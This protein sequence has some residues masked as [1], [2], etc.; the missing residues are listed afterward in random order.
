MLI[1]PL[2]EGLVM[3]LTAPR[4]VSVALGRGGPRV[5]ACA[6]TKPDFPPLP[7]RLTR[8][9]ARR[10]ISAGRITSDVE[11][12]GPLL[13]LVTHGITD[14][15]TALDRRLEREGVF[16][17]GI[18][19]EGGRSSLLQGMLFP[20]RLASPTGAG[21]ALRAVAE[22]LNPF[23]SPGSSTETERARLR[24]APAASGL[25]LQLGDANLT[26]GHITLALDGALLSALGQGTRYITSLT[27]EPGYPP[28]DIET[29]P[30]VWRSLGAFMEWLHAGELYGWVLPTA[31]LCRN[32]VTGIGTVSVLDRP[33]SR[34]ARPEVRLRELLQP[35]PD[36][37]PSPISI[38]VT[39][40]RHGWA[41]MTISAGGATADVTLS[42]VFF[43]LHDL[44]EWAARL[45]AGDLPMEVEVDEEGT[46]A[47]L[48]AHP[49]AEP[50][51]V[52]LTIHERYGTE[53]RL[54]AL[55]H[56]MALAEALRDAMVRSL[57]D[58]GQAQGWEEFVREPGEE[59]GSLSAFRT[60]LGQE[61]PWLREG[62]GDGP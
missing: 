13:L 54:Q 40:D 16:Q 32:G 30:F 27:D 31:C 15:R 33:H 19:T 23:P 28:A 1:L 46:V 42:N 22:Q 4:E 3:R 47:V 6:V 35:R 11:T 45:A 20:L 29:A 51:V 53:M 36:R 2:C 48:T 21:S 43:P 56:R 58:K 59:E 10:L 50:D 18:R 34:L 26:G 14:A 9:P 57:H 49:I 37:E 61:W 24:A 17:V 41:S 39:A 7:E 60:S 5:G 8:R 12:L 25:G 62:R 38:T 52:L 44:L 55:V